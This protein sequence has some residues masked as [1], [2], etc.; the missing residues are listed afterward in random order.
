MTDGDEQVAP[1]AAVHRVRYSA[2]AAGLTLSDPDLAAVTAFLAA[3]AP[4]LDALAAVGRELA[5][6]P[7]EHAASPAFRVEWR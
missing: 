6:D 2:A 5:A 3:L 1:D 4:G 7:D